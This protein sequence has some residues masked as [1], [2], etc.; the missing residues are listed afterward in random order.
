MSA[1]LLMGEEL[2]KILLSKQSLRP[3]LT[4]EPMW[5]VEKAYI[6]P[7]QQSPQTES[8]WAKLQRW[9][10]KAGVQWKE[11]LKVI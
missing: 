6:P 8:T 9:G 3:H 7:Q 4:K 11:K 2:S 10:W 1:G 5:G